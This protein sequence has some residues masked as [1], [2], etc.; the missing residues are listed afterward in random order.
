MTGNLRNRECHGTAIEHLMLG[1]SK[2][3]PQRMQPRLKALKD[4]EIGARLHPVPRSIVERQVQVTDAWRDVGS[5][6]PI[7][8][9]KL[10]MLGMKRHDHSTARERSG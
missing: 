3:Y 2:V 8:R 4:D 10:Q 6:R 9:C 5:G 7:D 1:V